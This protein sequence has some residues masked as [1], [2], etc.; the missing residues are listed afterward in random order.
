MNETPE[1]QAFIGMG[2]NLGDSIATLKHALRALDA[3]PDTRVARASRL[4]RTAAWGVTEQ[5]DFINAVA[6]L[7]TRRAPRELLGDLLAIEREAG[8]RRLEDGSDRW[9]PR[10]LDL[11]L[12][13]YGEARI[14][15]PGLHVPHPRL[16]E[17]AFVLVP[18]A[19]IAPDARIPDVGT[20]AQALARMAP[21]QVE[22]VTYA[23]PLDPA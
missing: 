20:A 9:G 15:E 22:G 17:R 12:L 10:T 11:D 18:L 8:R 2:S 13:L 7:R 1:S 16:H 5:P 6:L 19:E 3:L 23:D 4:Y 14:D 21:S